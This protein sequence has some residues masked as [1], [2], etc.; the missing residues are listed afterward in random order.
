MAIAWRQFSKT[1]GLLSKTDRLFSSVFENR[2][3]GFRKP[4]SG[5]DWADPA[6]EFGWA[7]LWESGTGPLLKPRGRNAASHISP[8]RV[9]R[10]IR[11]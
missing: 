2:P 4:A 3:S 6:S 9:E 7:A 5:F 1:D 11:M 10:E 8:G